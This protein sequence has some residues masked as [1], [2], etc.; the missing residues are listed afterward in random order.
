MCISFN[1]T[2]KKIIGEELAYLTREH[3]YDSWTYFIQ[4]LEKVGRSNDCEIRLLWRILETELFEHFPSSQ[5][6]VDPSTSN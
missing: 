1:V 5:S 6:T 4:S 2:R 3:V